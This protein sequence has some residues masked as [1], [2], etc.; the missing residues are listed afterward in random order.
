MRLG[1][2]LGLFCWNLGCFAVIYMTLQNCLIFHAVLQYFALNVD[3][4]IYLTSIIPIH[5]AILMLKLDER[6]QAM[7]SQVQS[8]SVVGCTRNADRALEGET[9]CIPKGRPEV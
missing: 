5:Q 3:F 4:I 8:S 9:R 6:E 2:I 1:A 7:R